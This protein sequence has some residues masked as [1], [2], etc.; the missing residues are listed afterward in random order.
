MI[1]KSIESAL[2]G[3]IETY[4]TQR[5]LL[6]VGRYFVRFIS[7]RGP[8]AIRRRIEARR[9]LA[10]MTAQSQRTPNQIIVAIV[11]GG[12]VGD[13]IIAARFLRDL[14]EFCPNVSFDIYTSNVALGRWIYGNVGSGLRDCFQ[15]TSFGKISEEYDAILEIGDT[16]K[17]LQAKLTLTNNHSERLSKILAS[18]RSFSDGHK[19]DKTLAYNHDGIVA[20]ELLYKHGKN[21]ATANHFIAGI[22]YGGDRYALA[23]DEN[24][25][26]KHALGDKRYVTVHNGFDLSQIT[27]SGTA[28]KVYPRFGEVIKEVRKAR[29]ELIFVQIGASTSVN[30]DGVDLNLIGQ[31]SLPEAAGLIKGAI[32]HLDN[33][34]GLVTIASCYGIRCCVVF[35]PS[36]A[37]YFSYDGNVAIRPAECGGCW[38][39]AKDWMSRCPRGMNEPVCMYKQP[40]SVVAK[41]VLQLLNACP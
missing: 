29:P 21:R 35:G 14:G 2:S 10:R 34:G 39:I 33:E 41:G 23:A 30:I 17:F 4:R 37:D 24:V 19:D 40:P 18:I 32:C 16:V 11:V 9:S 15:D 31:T 20:Q 36:S 38:W 6:A 7:R 1:W 8:A 12:V 13:N 5:S 28:S 22:S 25:V 27:H 3:A 26:A